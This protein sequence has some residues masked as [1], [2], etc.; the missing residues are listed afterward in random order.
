MRS[1]SRCLTLQALHVL[2]NYTFFF[3]VRCPSSG[4]WQPEIAIVSPFALESGPSSPRKKWS[5]NIPKHRPQ[6]PQTPRLEHF[7][8]ALRREGMPTPSFLRAWKDSNLAN[9]CALSSLGCT[10][11]GDTILVDTVVRVASSVSHC[12]KDWPS[13]HIWIVPWGSGYIKGLGRKKVE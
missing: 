1:P 5:E 3:Q 10:Y 4:M 11:M 13:T 7:R 9:C 2:P 6:R 8:S 12:G